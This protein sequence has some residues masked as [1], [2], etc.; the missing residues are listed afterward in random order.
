MSA[1]KEILSI[2]SENE[3]AT[4]LLFNILLSNNS[5]TEKLQKAAED[6]AKEVEVTSD[7]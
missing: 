4:D 2:Y 3:A 1:T 5:F 6:V 7:E